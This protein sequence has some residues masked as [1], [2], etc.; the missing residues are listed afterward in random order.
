VDP[1]L[2]TRRDRASEDGSVSG[3]TQRAIEKSEIKSR[4]CWLASTIE[5]YSELVAS[6]SQAEPKRPVAEVTVLLSVRSFE[7]IVFE[8]YRTPEASS[9]DQ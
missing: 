7:L 2:E 1:S 6:K 9:Q 8:S 5:R 3:L 4:F